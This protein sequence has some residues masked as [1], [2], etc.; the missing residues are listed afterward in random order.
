MRLGELIAAAVAERR[1]RD[2]RRLVGS[3]AETSE[4]TVVEATGEY[5]AL[6]AAFL[7]SRK[8]LPKFDQALERIAEAEQPVMRIE[9]IGPLPPTAF[10]AAAAGGG[11]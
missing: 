5:V 10:A 2:S 8:K 7:V 1:E 6:K 9:V 3:L 4:D 11:G